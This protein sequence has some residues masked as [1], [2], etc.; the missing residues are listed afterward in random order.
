MAK[1]R[2]LIIEDERDMI[3]V[4]TYSLQREGFEIVRRS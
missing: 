4:L 3:D 2:V 1:P